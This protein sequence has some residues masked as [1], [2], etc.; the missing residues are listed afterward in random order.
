MTNGAER[1]RLRVLALLERHGWNATSFQILEAGF[2]YWFDGDDACVAYVDTGGAW[3]AAGAPIARAERLGR[4]VRAV[5]RARRARAAGAS[6]SSPPSRA[7][8]TRPSLAALQIGEQPVWD[9]ARW[10]TTVAATRGAARAAA[11]RREQGR[12]ACARVARERAR[13]PARRCA[14]RSRR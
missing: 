7:S 6:A 1:D 8:S 12:R 10:A 9:A 2:R 13:A 14:R 5:R 4:G 11:P 3:V